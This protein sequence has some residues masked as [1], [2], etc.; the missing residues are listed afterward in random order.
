MYTVKK[1]LVI[2]F[3]V[4]T[5]LK[6][7]QAQQITF[8][9]SFQCGESF[10]NGM[11]IFNIPKKVSE[12][13][14]MN[15][16]PGVMTTEKGIRYF[17]KPGT[18]I[19]GIDAVY[20][21]V[22]QDRIH[23]DKYAGV[24][25]L[26]FKSKQAMVPVLTGLTTQDY[27]A[28]MIVD[29]YLIMVW[30][31]ASKNTAETIKSVYDHFRQKLGVELYEVKPEQQKQDTV[32]VVKQEQSDAGVVDPSYYVELG[33]GNVETSIIDK[34]D[35]LILNNRI[36]ALQRQYGV[37]VAF[38]QLHPDD[39][40]EWDEERKEFYAS[41]LVWTFEERIKNNVVIMF[42]KESGKCWIFYGTHNKQRFKGLTLAMQDNFEHHY[43][44]IGAE[45]AMEV[46]LSVI[47]Q[48]YKK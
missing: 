35:A 12:E 6:P 41:H 25:V 37:E 7:V 24:Y 21:E 30:R 36:S 8:P 29:N 20:Y 44:T 9:Q 48:V 23:D 39:T 18:S 4:L 19:E 15:Q 22:Y 27:V 10:F 34:E 11:E 14:G 2:S 45:K 46:V 33:F 40:Q 16:N 31:S 43:K 28:Y 1:L 42:D 5:Y 47:E 38:Q 32:A 13:I 17:L 26:Q 3:V